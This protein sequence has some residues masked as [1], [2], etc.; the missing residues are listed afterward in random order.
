MPRKTNQS[1][2]CNVKQLLLKA[3]KQ[4]LRNLNIAYKQ[5]ATKSMN[6]SKQER[7]DRLIKQIMIDTFLAKIN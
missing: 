5:L 3:S 2:T 4:K 7:L 6:A 1:K